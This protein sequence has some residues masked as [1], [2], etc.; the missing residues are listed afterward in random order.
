MFLKD[1]S[2]NPLLYKEAKF[3][4]DFI[5]KF[6]KSNGGDETKKYV[7]IFLGILIDKIYL[8]NNNLTSKNN[9]I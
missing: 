6:C 1:Q 5:Q 8:E 7:F 4:N 9:L 3:L 2:L